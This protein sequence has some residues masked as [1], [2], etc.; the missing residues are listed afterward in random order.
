MNN[1][2]K[3]KQTQ[4]NSG[5]M[6]TIMATKSMNGNFGEVLQIA[7]SF[8]DTSRIVPHEVRFTFPYAI[9]ITFAC[10]LYLK[11]LT[12]KSKGSYETGHSIFTIYDNLSPIDKNNIL[13]KYNKTSISKNLDLT[14][15]L[16]AEGNS[17]I[18]WRYAF[19]N[20]NLSFTYSF[21]D[22][23]ASILREY[24]DSMI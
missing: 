18:D 8:L 9:N 21:W 2:M 17:F 20:T 16:N 15:I 4:T 19:E 12:D 6:M 13:A 5:L 14:T 22:E 10:E 1:K 24:V 7:N 3:G 23:F 11:I